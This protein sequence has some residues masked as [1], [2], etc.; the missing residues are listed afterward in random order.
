MDGWVTLPHRLRD[1]FDGVAV[2]HV[3]DLRLGARFGGDLLE[4]LAASRE[5]DAVPAP[6][7]ER[8]RERGADAA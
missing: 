4:P 3:A 2:A 1:A 8:P 7:A 5:E 6:P